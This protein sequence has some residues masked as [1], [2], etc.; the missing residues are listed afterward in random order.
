[1]GDPDWSNPTHNEGIPVASI[2][3]YL[4]AKNLHTNLGP[5]K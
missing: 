4:K 5:Q 3:N 2:Q 1:M